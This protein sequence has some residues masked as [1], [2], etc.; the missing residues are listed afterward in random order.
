MASKMS[1]DMVSDNLSPFHHSDDDPLT[2]K[3]N[4]ADV[5]VGLTS[6]VKANASTLAL[7]AKKLKEEKDF[8]T[9][10]GVVFPIDDAEEMMTKIKEK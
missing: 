2:P 10:S 6:W 1:L 5:A 8:L 7:L 3:T 9:K 4:P